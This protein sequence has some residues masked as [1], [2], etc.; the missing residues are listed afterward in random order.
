MKKDIASNP[1]DVSLLCLVRIVFKLDDILYLFCAVSLGVFPSVLCRKIL[2]NTL[3]KDVMRK[4]FG[5]HQGIYR[6]IP[7]NPVVKSSY[8]EKFWIISESEC[9]KEVFHIF[10]IEFAVMLDRLGSR[11]RLYGNFPYNK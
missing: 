8:R 7:Y 3:I 9:K 11:K 1:V 4:S 2:F 6:K 10:Q 5:S